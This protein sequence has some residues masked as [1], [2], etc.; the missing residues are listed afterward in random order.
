MIDAI[1][2]NCSKDEVGDAI[3][4]L[5]EDNRLGQW[6]N[7]VS[8]S[9]GRWASLSPPAGPWDSKRVLTLILH[10]NTGLAML[11]LSCQ[12]ALQFFLKSCQ[13]V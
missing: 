5:V 1:V 7:I 11:A 6:S 8:G 9:S 4:R 10:S 3:R 13:A 12:A 2:R